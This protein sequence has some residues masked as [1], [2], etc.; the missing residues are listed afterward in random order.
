MPVIQRRRTPG[1]SW[2]TA[3]A[4][5]DRNVSACAAILAI[6]IALLTG[7]SP[8]AAPTTGAPSAQTS[9]S[10]AGTSASE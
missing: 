8:T 3:P 10:T 1:R 4:R 2:C 6:L 9:S 5:R 7:G